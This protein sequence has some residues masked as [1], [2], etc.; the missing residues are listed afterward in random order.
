MQRFRRTF[1]ENLAILHGEATEFCEAEVGR[2]LGNRN[3]LAARREQ[4]SSHLGQA[5]H[6]QMPGWW[7]TVDFVE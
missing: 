7:P 6:A 4:S 1:A 5:Q 2:D 3:Q